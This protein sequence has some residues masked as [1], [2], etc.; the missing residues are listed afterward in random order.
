MSAKLQSSL[1]SKQPRKSRT[2]ALG[3]R[4]YLAP[5]ADDE[6]GRA[7]VSHHEVQQLLQLGRIDGR[8]ADMT[9]DIDVS[10]TIVLLCTNE[11]QNPMNRCVF[12]MPEVV[13]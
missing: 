3:R 4:L 6:V 5:R 12:T 1:V 10:D 11:L 2:Y 7:S 8:W 9:F 13:D